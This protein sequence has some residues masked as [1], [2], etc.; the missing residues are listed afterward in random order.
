MAASHQNKSL[1]TYLPVAVLGRGHE[2]LAPAFARGVG[3]HLLYGIDGLLS[4]TASSSGNSLFSGNPY[5]I[6]PF[7]QTSLI[8]T[9]KHLSCVFHAGNAISAPSSPFITVLPEI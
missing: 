2:R 4:V 7:T 5:A 6:A 1:I 8:S 9:G 3:H